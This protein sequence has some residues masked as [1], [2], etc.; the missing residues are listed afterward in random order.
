LVIN[1]YVEIPTPEDIYIT[2][3][4]IRKVFSAA[5]SEDVEEEDD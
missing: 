5:Q 2:L 4:T 3:N 1:D